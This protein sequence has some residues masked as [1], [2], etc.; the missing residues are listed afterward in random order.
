[1]LKKQND[2]AKV[3][4]A[5]KHLMNVSN[6][7]IKA[8]DMK[9][10]RIQVQSQILDHK[11]RTAEQIASKQINDKVI[12]ARKLGTERVEFVKETKSSNLVYDDNDIQ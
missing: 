1:M 8:I 2:D 11:M 7:Y 5:H 4:K 3:Q 12:N 9:S 6:S 10:T